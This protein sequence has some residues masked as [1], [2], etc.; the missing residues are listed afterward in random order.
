MYL[1]T[2]VVSRKDS[3]SS[4]YQTYLLN[5]SIPLLGSKESCCFPLLGSACFYLDLFDKHPLCPEWT[6]LVP[7]IT[8]P[9][10]CIAQ[11]FQT[12]V[13][14]LSQTRPGLRSREYICLYP[15]LWFVTILDRHESH[16]LVDF[17]RYCKENKIITLYIL[18]HSSHLLQPLDVGCFGLLKR[19]YGKEIKN[20]MRVHISHIIKI[21]F[22]AAFKNAF[23]AS[24]G[25]ANIRGGF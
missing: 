22:F 9:P 2:C 10:L 16:I 23:I 17:Q 11:I 21:E 24:F 15:Y 14:S 5:A 12:L 19:L 13:V 1:K 25:E 20:L 3:Y 4:S 8:R 7:T 18:A 6:L